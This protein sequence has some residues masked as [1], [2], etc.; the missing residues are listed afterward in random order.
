MGVPT[1]AQMDRAI[2][3]KHVKIWRIAKRKDSLDEG[4]I[5]ITLLLGLAFVVSMLG[6]TIVLYSIQVPDV[7]KDGLRL[8]TLVCL[9][10]LSGLIIHLSLKKIF[11]GK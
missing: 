3:K 1:L 10:G 4:G 6:S 2:S 5:N 7:A 11:G 9:V 8:T